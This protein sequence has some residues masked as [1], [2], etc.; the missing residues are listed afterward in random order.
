MRSAGIEVEALPLPEV[1]TGDDLAQLIVGAVQLHDGDVVV[2]T[3]KIISKAEGRVRSS[4]RRDA[5]AAES[6]RVLAQRGESVI[7]ETRHGLVMAAAG[8]DGSNTPAGTVLLLP[9]DPDASARRLRER[10]RDITGATVGVVVTDTAGRAWRLGQTDMAIGCAGLAPMVDLH[11]TFDTHGNELN[12]TAPAVAD[13]VAAAGDLVKGKAMGR[14]VAV[15][16][17]LDDLVLPDGEHGPGADVLVRETASDL[18][19]LGAREAAVAAAM[20]ADQVALAHFPPRTPPDPEPFAELVAVS[21]KAADGPRISVT[22]EVHHASD[23]ASPTQR[24]DVQ[25]DVPAHPS[26]QAL[27]EAGRLIERAAVIAAA[28]RLTPEPGGAEAT[29]TDGRL[30]VAHM[31]W[32]S[33]GAPSE[34]VIADG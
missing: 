9:V 4:D 33:P 23:T 18:F 29:P 13:E 22:T 25:V 1:D 28:Y 27:V 5:I 11:G 32:V 10:L 3:S 8:V 31:H 30:V 2:V 6:R 24:Y 26:P 17:G 16:R 21:S 14:P 12:V 19:G 7:A 34:H 20:R 15:V